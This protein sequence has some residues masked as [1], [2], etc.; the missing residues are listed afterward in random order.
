MPPMLKHLWI[1]PVMAVLS[2]AASASESL[3]PVSVRDYVV[4]RGGGYIKPNGEFVW[5]GDEI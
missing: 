2:A 5:R 1:F 3:Y 4:G